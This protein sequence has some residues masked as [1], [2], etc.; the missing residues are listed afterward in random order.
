MVKLTKHDLTDLSLEI[1]QNISEAF[2][3]NNLTQAE[4]IMVSALIYENLRLMHTSNFIND[5]LNK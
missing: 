5:N 1:T 2:T 3:E 4:A